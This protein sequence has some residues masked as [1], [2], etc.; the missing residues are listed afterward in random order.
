MADDLLGTASYQANPRGPQPDF[1]ASRFAA[2]AAGLGRLM[3]TGG[4]WTPE[5]GPDCMFISIV[6]DAPLES[7][8][9]MREP[10][11]CANCDAMPCIAA[12]PTCALATETVEVTVSGQT[13]RIGRLDW[14]R[15][16]WA[17]RYGLV[18]DAG[19]RWIGSQTNILPPA[20]P[21]TIEQVAEAY[22]QLDPVQ[23]HWMCIVEPCLR[24]CHLHTRR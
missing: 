12:C 18:G 24:A 13:E 4:V 23:K 6:T 2:V 17:K 16:E 19:P 21:L 5:H 15:C 7:S 22:A 20:G 1:R 14:L 11:P 3:Q 9:P 8:L 10:P